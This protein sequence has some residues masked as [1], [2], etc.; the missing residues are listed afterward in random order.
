MSLSQESVESNV[1]T[2][3]EKKEFIKGFVKNNKSQYVEI[4]NETCVDSIYNLMKT[5]ELKV[6]DTGIECLYYGWYC[7]Y[8]SKDFTKMKMYYFIG[9][10]K[11]N[12]YCS[13][14]LA[15][16]YKYSKK[17]ESK[18]MKYASI[19]AES[20]P[21]IA[22][23][24]AIHY[25]EKKQYDEMKK[26]LEKAIGMG[27]TEAMLFYADYYK[28]QKD[29]DNFV[30]YLLMVLDMPYKNENSSFTRLSTIILLAKYYQD[31]KDYENMKMYLD[32]AIKEY[33]SVHALYYYGSYHQNIT[34]DYNSMKEYYTM[35]IRQNDV[36]SM[37]KLAEHY[38]YIERDYH[39]AEQLLLCAIDHTV[40]KPEEVEDFVYICNELAHLYQYSKKDIG[41]AIKYYEM[42]IN[43]KSPSI[44]SMYNLGR[45][46]QTELKD[47]EKMKI[48]YDM[49]INADYSLNDVTLLSYFYLAVTTMKTHYEHVE[50]NE[51]KV[52]EYKK[53]ISEKLKGLYS[54]ENLS[55]IGITVPLGSYTNNSSLN[56]ILESTGILDVCID[57]LGYEK[58]SYNYGSTSSDIISKYLNG[59]LLGG[60]GKRY[61]VCPDY[62]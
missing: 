12:P 6:V 8:I 3:D 36:A 41:N 32:M 52:Q 53:K 14:N 50:K 54:F 46:Y 43:C 20:N 23:R 59:S 35:A 58:K 24:L 9:I 57:A 37:C 61:M 10:Q 56:S 29:Y 31:T 42:A 62:C 39:E 26:Y 22:T 51:E 48:Y 21:I 44:E 13:L 33:K 38:R 1:L 5:G 17:N 28:T 47:Y 49:A 16:Y 60:Y 19:G 27:S 11:G 25:K 40:N 4:E 2:L 7:Q 30:K 55:G 34:K 18:Y 45:L 15:S